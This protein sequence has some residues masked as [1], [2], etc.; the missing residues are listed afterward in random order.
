MTQTTYTVKKGE[1]LAQI[2]AKFNLSVNDLKQANNIPVNNNLIHPAQTLIIPDKTTNQLNNPLSTNRKQ[3]RKDSL[4]TAFQPDP[5]GIG[6]CPILDKI[7]IFPVRYAIDESP[8]KKGTSQG[9]HPIP[10]DWDW[11]L[12]PKKYFPQINTRSYTLRQLRD[13]WLYVYD[14]TD[15]ELHEY[16]IKGDTFTLINIFDRNAKEKQR[17][18]KKQ[19]DNQQKPQQ[20]DTKKYLEYQAHR[21][22]L[23]YSAVRCT[24]RI[25]I[26]LCTP[27]F[28]KWA[29]Q[30][31]L[32][33]YCTDQDRT[34]P[35]TKSIA[36]LGKYVADIKPNAL[37]HKSYIEKNPYP[38]PSFATTSTPTVSQASDAAETQ[39]IKPIINETTIQGAMPTM[40]TGIFV[41]LD[42]PL[43]IIDDLTI[44]LAG[45]WGEGYQFEQD[46]AHK[47]GVAEQ[48]LGLIG[49]ELK[50][51]VP[52]RISH[53]ENKPEEYYE[54]LKDIY[55]LLEKQTRT[56][57]PGTVNPNID[58]MSE[59]GRYKIR[60]RDELAWQYVDFKKKWHYRVEEYQPE[61]TSTH[62]TIAL[63]DIF[64]ASQN[65]PTIH[66]SERWRAKYKEWDTV[67]T[68]REDLRFDEMV[69]YLIQIAKDKKRYQDHIHK[70]QPDL[71][72]W[73]NKLDG[74]VESV[75]LDPIDEDQA[76]ELLETTET[77]TAFL[78]QTAQGKEWI[79]LQFND[80]QV[81][82]GLAHYNFSKELYEFI[83]NIIA[84]IEALTEKQLAQKIATAKQGQTPELQGLLGE[85]EGILRALDKVSAVNRANE[86]ASVISLDMVK[87]HALYKT[88]DDVTHK[89]FDTL[90]KMSNN[91]TKYLLQGIAN[92]TMALLDNVSLL[93]YAAKATI[94]NLGP[95]GEKIYLT[96]NQRFATEMADWQ[97]AIKA[98]KQEITKLTDKKAI[99]LA[100]QQLNLLES[101]PPYKWYIE[102]GTSH[103][104]VPIMNYRP[105]LNALL[106][107]ASDTKTLAL[108]KEWTT[109]GRHIIKGSEL[110]LIVLAANLYN[111]GSVAK[112]LQQS[113]TPE[114]MKEFVASAGYAINTAMSIWVSPVASSISPHLFNKKI[115]V[116]SR[117]L[118]YWLA[119]TS[120][121]RVEIANLMSSLRSGFMMM[122][123]VGTVAAGFELWGAVDELKNTTS[124]EEHYW[125]WGKVFILGLMAGS[126]GIQTLLS[127]TAV[128][129]KF[130]WFALHPGF[131]IAALIL[132]VIYL[133]VSTYAKYYKRDGVRL[134][135]H[136]CSWGKNENFWPDTE[137]GHLQEYHA[138]YKAVLQP[139]VI[140]N[141]LA[142][143]LLS[144][145]ERTRAMLGNSHES[146]W[147][148]IAL[149]EKMEGHNIIIDLLLV[150]TK[151][152][153]KLPL[154]T[155]F[156]QQLEQTRY[157]AKTSKPDQP[158][159]LPK[160]PLKTVQADTYYS[161]D[162][163]HRLLYI[164]L[165]TA[166]IDKDTHITLEVKITY[167]KIVFNSQNNEQ[168][169]DHY[170]YR[171][172]LNDKTYNTPCKMVLDDYH[173]KSI[174]KEQ[175]LGT[176]LTQ[177]SPQIIWVPTVTSS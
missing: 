54:C 133:A 142:K 115:R 32:N 172:E 94:V 60:Q 76:K 69:D 30:L 156:Y 97:A 99:T 55:A 6:T 17:D 27:F 129:F 122:S 128:W 19:N 49:A 118:N 50:D 127:F 155:T 107:R 143:Q 101:T 42:D 52:D 34:L 136:R 175:Q 61:D 36:E 22:F 96:R 5:K 1:S 146:I 29:R 10:D 141:P 18:P 43:A 15:D 38:N 82:I 11:P 51:F 26:K 121:T 166:S 68:W 112:E 135:L 137:N 53:N 33:T 150:D 144:P 130:G 167:P 131:A 88:L 2:A 139:T 103:Q 168:L 126:M 159:Q 154:S 77:I 90:Y 44:N 98:K 109:Q 125:A 111:F 73:L 100:K 20:G 160:Y 59:S 31:D 83:K 173:Q 148:G 169:T 89:L 46:N 138:L 95:S 63:D 56:W 110:P 152:Q 161:A 58:I 67:K 170:L 106:S 9:A 116:V 165:D 74:N 57:E 120:G 12:T 147:V 158:L 145:D 86:I 157:W 117:S 80:P 140:V 119:R 4:N 14:W 92:N 16:E 24:D 23:S 64:P 72:A 78:N 28:S 105:L 85:R 177:N 124:T 37:H 123:L 3:A 47:A 164:W 65:A 171:L 108:V 162:N 62:H 70:Y 66:L 79:K 163:K 87:N 21:I 134:W 35:H 40:D 25:K 84:E 153:K 91:S 13:G 48:C 114:K 71:I 176:S 45:R 39:H 149:P 8:T 113:Y 102:I 174:P 93:A 104:G 81:F 151:T 41:A 132:G 7:R 75:F